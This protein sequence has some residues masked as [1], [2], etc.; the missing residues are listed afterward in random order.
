MR[1]LRRAEQ[2][3]DSL[4]ARRRTDGARRPRH[5]PILDAAGVSGY[6][7]P[8]VAVPRSRQ[9]RRRPAYR[10]TL[11]EHRKQRAQAARSRRAKCYTQRG[12][13]LGLGKS[14]VAYITELVHRRPKVW[15]RDIDELNDL[16]EAHG[17]SAL[18]SAVAHC[19]EQRVFGHEYIA[20]HLNN[21]IAAIGVQ[22]E[23]FS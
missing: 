1:P 22:Q 5:A 2:P 9:D 14:T 17:D 7:V 20:H 13:L 4:A 18:Q 15:A 10:R 8:A 3:R 6:G 19:L 12:Q 16:L 23:L 21:R 11:P